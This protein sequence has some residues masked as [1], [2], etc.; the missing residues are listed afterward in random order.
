M[1]KIKQDD[2]LESV[3]KGEPALDCM[4]GHLSQD[5]NDNKEPA[6]HTSWARKLQAKTSTKFLRW[7]RSLVGSRGRH[8]AQCGSSLS[9]E[10]GILK[11]SLPLDSKLIDTH[12]QT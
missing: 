7:K 5:R 1:T 8:R 2:R 6:M 4:R 9:R 11:R 10:Q 3:L 12:G